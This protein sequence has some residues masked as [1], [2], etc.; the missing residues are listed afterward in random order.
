M[1]TQKFIPKDGQVD[2]TNIRYAPVVNIVVV[3]NDKIL[4][5]HRSAK[6]RLYPDYWNGVSGFLDDNQ[7]IEDKVY[8]ELAEEL[9]IE[10]SDVLAI[11]RG[12]PLLQEAPE[13]GK[14]WFIVPIKAEVKTTNVTTDWEAQKVQ[15]FTAQEA[16]NLRLLPGFSEVLKQFINLKPV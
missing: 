2:Y 3:K 5:A 8:E 9:S 12:Q 15:W 16:Q 4:L 1:A 6:M 10:R 11:T 14:T 13:Y 7:D